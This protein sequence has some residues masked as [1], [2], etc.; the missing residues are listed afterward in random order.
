MKKL[1]KYLII[2]LSITLVL[3]IVLMAVSPKNLV[4]EK[5]IKIE[6]PAN[7][8]Y[9]LV[10]DLGKWELWSPWFQLDPEAEHTYSD[11]TYG[12]GAKWNWKGNEDLGEGSQT[13]IENDENNAVK[14]ALEFQGWDGESFSDWVFTEKDGATEI[15]WDFQGSDT[16]FF[17]RPF[18]LLMKSG[19]AKSYKE[20]L[21]AL[22][23]LA[24]ERYSKNI[25]RGFEIKQ[26]ELEERNFV[27]SRQVVAFENMQ[28]FYA[29]NL[30]SL[31]GRVQAAGLEM[32]GMPCGLFFDY[33]EM[34]QETDM[35]AAI[36]IASDVT[37][38][39]IM[40]HRIPAGMAI[41][42][43]YRGDYQGLKEA[44]TAIDEY[45]KDRLL[46]SNPPVVEEYITDPGQEKDPSKW[47][48]RI[49]YYIPSI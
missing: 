43:D 6:A 44:H 20:G 17:F 24:E 1:A 5:S 14:M 35:A 37:I 39:G 31:F 27:V 16:P 41:Q 18:N 9:N 29:Q 33:D 7:V 34:A 40:S 4:V 11:I 42:L 45:M 12:A 36:P 2:I 48:T 19:L 13:I 46:L 8:C 25:Y 28:Q 26:T 30:G 3:S 38:E 10:N 32:Q 21:A 22:K 49:S 47:L 15:S 23:G